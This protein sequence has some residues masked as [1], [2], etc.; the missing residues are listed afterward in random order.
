MALLLLLLL[1]LLV[2]SLTMHIFYLILPLCVYYTLWKYTL[3]GIFVIRCKI[4]CSTF[5][6]KRHPHSL[7]INKECGRREQFLT[8]TI[9]LRTLCGM[10]EEAEWILHVMSRYLITL[11]IRFV[12]PRDRPVS[13]ATNLIQPPPAAEL[14][15]KLVRVVQLRLYFQFGQDTDNKTKYFMQ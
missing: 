1:L 3:H 12:A 11:K 6:F 7:L 13:T 9:H 5:I 4:S 2:P 10:G 15:T 14:H 8:W